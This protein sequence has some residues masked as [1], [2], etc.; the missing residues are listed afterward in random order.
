[1]SSSKMCSSLDRRVVPDLAASNTGVLPQDVIYEILLRLPAKELC[2][3]RAVCR[4]WSSLLSDPKNTSLAEDKNIVNIVDLSGN[5][6]R[7]VRMDDPL[8]VTVPLNLVWELQTGVENSSYRLVNPASGAFYD[9]SVNLAE[10]HAFLGLKFLACFK[11]YLIGQVPSTGE[12]KVLRWTRYFPRRRRG[13]LY[14]ICTLASGGHGRWRVMQDSPQPF[15]WSGM[16]RVVIDGIMYFLTVDAQLAVVHRNQV[17]EQDCIVSFDLNTEEWRSSI[18][19]PQSIFLDVRSNHDEQS[20]K[21]LTLGNLNGPLV[22]VHGTVPYVDLWFLIDFEE[23]SWVKQYSIHFERYGDIEHVHPVSVLEDGR[24][25]I[26]IERMGLLQIYDPKTCTFIDV[27]KG[28]RLSGVI[29]YTGNLL[30]LE[31]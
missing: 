29:M 11:S 22:V 13:D 24:I 9:V 16:T 14:E 6:V 10:E 26:Y 5:I 1:M 18:R 31:W 3:L 12:Y 25:V 17:L 28:R 8:I 19:G 20:P 2:R 21:H 23:G 30:S 7:Q 15:C 4:P 27:V